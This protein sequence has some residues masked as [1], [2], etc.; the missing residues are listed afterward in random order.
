MQGFNAN[1]R[2]MPVAVYKPKEV[3]PADMA[4]VVYHEGKL[5]EFTPHVRGHHKDGSIHIEH[6][7]L[8]FDKTGKLSPQ[9]DR[10]EEGM[11]SDYQPPEDALLIP[12]RFQ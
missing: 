1:V 6:V 3:P 10:V 7:V 11:D 9:S 12:I 4:Y 8:I 2:F 5:V